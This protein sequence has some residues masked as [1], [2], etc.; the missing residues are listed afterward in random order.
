MS[1]K[2]KP[3]K[4]KMSTTTNATSSKD[5]DKEEEDNGK[6]VPASNDKRE[7]YKCG[8]IGHIAR[9]CPKKGSNEKSVEGQ[10]DTDELVG[11]SRN[12]LNLVDSKDIKMNDLDLDWQEGLC[13][14]EDKSKRMSNLV[15]S[16]VLVVYESD[17]HGFG[18]DSLE[19]KA[20]SHGHGTND[21]EE[22][23]GS[24][25]FGTAADEV[26]KASSHG[27]G[28]EDEKKVGSHGF[29]T[30]VDEEKVGSHG[31]GIKCEKYAGSHGCGTKVKDDK[32]Y[33]GSRGYDTK[34]EG[35]MFVS[36]QGFGTVEN[37]GMKQAWIGC[38]V[39]MKE[40]D[41]KYKA[42]EMGEHNLEQGRVLEG[43]KDGASIA[44]YSDMWRVDERKNMGLI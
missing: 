23:V 15:D 38:G 3:L 11:P 29:G 9:D 18:T 14:K 8:D 44:R 32:M 2:T 33:I 5:K 10:W 1:T 42:K 28:T 7:C 39:C 17:G 26:E 6:T 13:E 22:K 27:L 37:E 41:D 4:D 31:I 25:G 40:D 30:V 12:E 19:M 35:D 16:K 21:K 24:H 20:G 36:D 43:A 34:Y